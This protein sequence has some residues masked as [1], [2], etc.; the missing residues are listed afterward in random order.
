MVKWTEASVVKINVDGSS[1]YTARRAGVGC[2]ARIT[3][4]SR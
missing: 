4:G 3:W 1:S 2:V